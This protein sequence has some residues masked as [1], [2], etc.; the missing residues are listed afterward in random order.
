MKNENDWKPS[1][2]IKKDGRFVP[3][4]SE[5]SPGSYLACTLTF[6]AYQDAI[7]KYIA[8]DVLDCGCGRVPFY[9]MYKPN[10]S[11]ITC[12]DWQ[13][14]PHETNH[15]DDAM[16]LNEGLGYDDDKYDGIILTDVLEHIHQPANLIKDIY[17][18]LRPNGKV[19]V[20]VPFLY[21]VHEAPHDFF[22]YTEFQLRRM[23]EEQGFKVLELNPYG[24]YFESLFNMIQKFRPGSYWFYRATDLIRKGLMLL[25]PLR[26]INRSKERIFPLGYC[27]VV[28]KE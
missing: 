23:F 11:S 12:V 1:R 20:G 26:R 7:E 21:N 17:R 14:S 15:I 16:D 25:S 18:T 28:T 2:C 9:E 19:V 5:V 3:V 22:R 13:L 24:G 10:S 27:L 8:G 6:A 4:A